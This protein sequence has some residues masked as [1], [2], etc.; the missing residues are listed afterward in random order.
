MRTLEL[1]KV[2]NFKSIRDQTLRLGRLN[3]F[4]GGNGAGKSNLVGV[5]HFLN[6]VVAGDLQT[7]AGEAGGADSILYFGRKQSSSLSVDLEF[8]EGNDANG[9]AFELRPTAEDRFIFSNE[10]I[11][12]HDRNRYPSPYAIDLG[13]GH[14]EARIQQSSERIAGHVRDDLNSYRIYHFHDTSSSARVKQTG[15]VDDNRHLQSDAGN[16]AASL[17]RLQQKFTGH[18]QNIEDTIR[19]VAPF[20]EGFRLEP[21][22]L[23]ADKIRL[24]WKEKGSDAYFNASALSDGTLRFICLATLLLQPVLPAIVLLDE[25]ELGLHPVGIGLLAD[26]LESASQRTQVLVATQSVTLVNQ[27]TPE[28]VWVVERSDR[29]SVFTHLQSADMSAWLDNYSLGELWEKNILGGRP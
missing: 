8:V 4:I 18:L 19:Q 10:S 25:P 1:L 3:V 15:D 9:Y 22:R 21:S 27:F 20:F 23:N 28:S 14:S 6:R 7:Y 12:Y 29:Q 16:L 26:L 5:F 24:E 17:Y 13:T 11:S 2:K